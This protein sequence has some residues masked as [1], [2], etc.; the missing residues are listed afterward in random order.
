MRGEKDNVIRNRFLL[1]KSSL[2][3]VRLL[4]GEFHQPPKWLFTTWYSFSSCPVCVGV[5]H[6]RILFPNYPITDS[7]ACISLEIFDFFLSYNFFQLTCVHFW[8][9]MTSLSWQHL[10]IEKGKR[11][12]IWYLCYYL[13]FCSLLFVHFNLSS[14]FFLCSAWVIV[15]CAKFMLEKTWN[16][17][18]S[19]IGTFTIV[20]WKQQF[21][22][23]FTVLTLCHPLLLHF[24]LC[25]TF[26]DGKY[27]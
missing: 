20:W 16:E 22:H 9:V 6:F 3:E 7:L 8:G 14:A 11:S 25:P 27:H 23:R 21:H 5:L 15:F 18:K 10:S 24:D 19:N 2:R 4:Q 13:I 26:F 12:L 1:V 17:H